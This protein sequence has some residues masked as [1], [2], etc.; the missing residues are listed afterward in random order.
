MAVHP[1]PKPARKPEPEP[2]VEL[3]RGGLRPD[4]APLIAEAEQS[5]NRTYLEWRLAT[6]DDALTVAAACHHDLH[7]MWEHL[8]ARTRQIADD[9]RLSL[10]AKIGD[11]QEAAA[12]ALPRANG[13]AH[14]ALAKLEERK[15]ELQAELAKPPKDTDPAAA[16]ELRAVIRTR[17]A[18]ERSALVRRA[19][20]EGD[21]QI[22][23]AV[24]ASHPLLTGFDGELRAMLAADAHRLLRPAEA[25][26]LAQIERAI[27]HVSR[28]R[29]SW[30]R[31]VRET[32]AVRLAPRRQWHEAIE[33]D[34]IQPEPEPEEP[35]A[36]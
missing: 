15:A 35:P 2:E 25:A 16:A 31:R 5:L 23:S 24:Y 14:R 36:A 11:A 32:F 1:L 10:S 27:E 6:D 9:A 13:K 30:H 20:E 7:G 17:P 29:D 22:V 8:A 3:H 26:L 19:I 18:P 12:E 21:R 28:L 4:R 34:L 33:P